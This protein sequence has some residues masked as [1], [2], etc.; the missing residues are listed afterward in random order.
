MGTLKILVVLL[1]NEK[2]P[3]KNIGLKFRGRLRGEGERERDRVMRVTF[4]VTIMSPL[5]KFTIHDVPY[6]NI[7][8]VKIKSNLLQTIG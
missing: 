8:Y 7:I 2:V 3:T 5:R 4:E 1:T 6:K